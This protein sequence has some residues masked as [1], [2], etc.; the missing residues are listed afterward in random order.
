MIIISAV[1]GA[2]TYDIHVKTIDIWKFFT[3]I[4]WNR[5]YMAQSGS[6]KRQSQSYIHSRRYIVDNRYLFPNNTFDYLRG[7]YYH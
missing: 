6:I 3:T 1:F 4:L 5:H 2:N 7:S